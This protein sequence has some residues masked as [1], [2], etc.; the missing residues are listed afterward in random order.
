L[1]LGLEENVRTASGTQRW[2][3]NVDRSRESEVLTGLDDHGWGERRCVYERDTLHREV[4]TGRCRGEPTTELAGG[5][6]GSQSWA[7]VRGDRGAP[8]CEA[9]LCVAPRLRSRRRLVRAT[10]Q[11]VA[12]AR[13]QNPTA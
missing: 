8:L 13:G 1:V 6:C 4:V 11:L 10:S 3:E 5:G 2:H 9:A 12:Q 7:R